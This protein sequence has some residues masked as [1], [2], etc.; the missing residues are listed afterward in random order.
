MSAEALFE[1]FAPHGEV[2]KTSDKNMFDEG[3]VPSPISADTLVDWVL[4]RPLLT[5][6]TLGCKDS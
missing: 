3:L 1:H 4:L 6:T 5:V 2:R